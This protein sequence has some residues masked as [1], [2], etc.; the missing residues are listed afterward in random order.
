MIKCSDLLFILL[1]RC[2][3]IFSKKSNVEF[4]LGEE[5]HR[6]RL[7]GSVQVHI[8]HKAQRATLSLEKIQISIQSHLCIPIQ[9]LYKIGSNHQRTKSEVYLWFLPPPSSGS[10]LTPELQPLVLRP[11]L[12]S[13]HGPL[14]GMS[15]WLGALAQVLYVILHLP[16]TY[17][18]L[19]ALMGYLFINLEKWHMK[20]MFNVKTDHIEV[21]KV[22]CESTSLS[23]NLFRGNNCLQFVTCHFILHCF[24][25]M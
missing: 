23:I 22:K 21:L 1:F 15:H 13:D 8:L 9:K 11:V 14:G 24:Y 6:K 4:S 17:S 7:T 16:L 20:Y 5:K 25:H 19:L 3:E 10:S 18:L 12:W 2:V